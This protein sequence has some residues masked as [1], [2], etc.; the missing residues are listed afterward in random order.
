MGKCGVCRLDSTEPLFQPSLLLI[1]VLR[2]EI[3]EQRRP[4][5]ETMHFY[6]MCLEADHMYTNYFK[7]CAYNP[8]PQFSRL[9]IQV[10]LAT[11]TCIYFCL[12][13]LWLSG[14]RAKYNL[15]ILFGHC[16]QT[17]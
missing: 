15:Y 6:I 2:R 9:G 4:V 13:G 17:Y 16:V 8:P 3:E 14:T 12:S 10:S 11:C 7:T 5:I 1:H